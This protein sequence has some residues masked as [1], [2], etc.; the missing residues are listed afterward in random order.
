ME[1]PADP[2]RVII[3]QSEIKLTLRF[4]NESPVVETLKQLSRNTAGLIFSF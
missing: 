3:P 2:E 1:D 4:W